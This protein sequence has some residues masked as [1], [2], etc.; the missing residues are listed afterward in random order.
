MGDMPRKDDW[1]AV[2]T[3]PRLGGD[4]YPPTCECGHTYRDHLWGYS[5]VPCLK[6]GCQCND[7]KEADHG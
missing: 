1:V 6:D 4:L 7:M 5:T 2:V 3:E